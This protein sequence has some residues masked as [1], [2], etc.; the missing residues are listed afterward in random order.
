MRNSCWDRISLILG[1]GYMNVTAQAVLLKKNATNDC[2]VMSLH[3]QPPDEKY[4][5]MKQMFNRPPS[6]SPLSLAS[7]S[8]WQVRWK[9]IPLSQE[10]KGVFFISAH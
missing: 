3:A 9:S 5:G 1:A 4:I 6:V 7:Q 8:E 10:L 2:R